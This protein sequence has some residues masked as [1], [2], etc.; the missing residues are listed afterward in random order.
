MT[1]VWSVLAVRTPTLP[2]A[3]HTNAYLLGDTLV[4]PACP[5]PDEQVRLATW[6]G[7]IRRVLLTHHHLDHIGAVEAI[8]ARTGASVWAHTDARLPF[9]VDHRVVDGER[10]DTGAGVLVALHT[11]GHAD[12]HLAFE[13]EGTR[14]LI[15][16]DLVAGEG[17]IVLPAPEGDLAR[18]LA[19]LARVRALADRLWP[20]HGP[21]VP[22]ALADAYIAHRHAR[23]AQFVAVLG[24]GPATPEQVAATVYAAV[25]GVHLGL[26]AAQV[27][28]H[29]AWLRDQ[30]RV[31]A[32]GEVWSLV[33]GAP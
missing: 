29:L 22:A 25:P 12:G 16:G 24:A 19:S 11:P 32:E 4:D 9:P 30:G 28:T 14:E 27:R 20:A 33:G 1:P 23:T 10:I 31:A 7:P 17:T 6:A 2:P 26:A 18:Y 21:A 5:E 8:V 15:A 13:L 3:M